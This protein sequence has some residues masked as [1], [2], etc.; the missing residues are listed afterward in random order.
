MKRNI[1]TVFLLLACFLCNAKIILP[2]LVSDGMVLQRDMPVNVWGWADSEQKVELFL[3]SD[4]YQTEADENGNWKIQ[5]HAHSAGGSYNMIIKTND[6][7]ITLNDILFGDVWVCS[8]QSNME[9][10]VHRVLSLYKYIAANPNIRQFLV[11]QTYNFISPQN[12]FISGQWVKATPET[13]MDFTAVGYFFATELYQKH[14]V[15]VGLINNALGGSPVEA[16]ISEDSLKQYPAL[17]QEAVKYKNQSMIDSIIAADKIRDDTWHGELYKEDKGYDTVP[18]YS[19]NLD[20]KDWS[21]INIPGYWD[22]SDHQTVNGAIWF[23]KTFN[24]PSELAGKPALLLSG[25]IVDADDVYVNGK[26]VGNTTYM[27]PPR[28]Y[29]VPENLLKSG[30]NEITIRVVSR[31]G[32]GCFVEDKYY[33]LEFDNNDYSVSDKVIKPIVRINLSGEWL[34]KIGA[35]KEAL[36]PE[37][38]IRWKPVGLYNAK[39]A[40]LLNYTVKGVIWYQGESNVVRASNYQ[41]EF[42]TLI[43]DW[44]SKWKQGDFPFLYVQLSNYMKAYDKPSESDWAVLRE[45]QTNTLSVPNTAMVVTIDIGEWNDIHPLNKKD[46]GKRLALAAEK[47]AYNQDIEYSGP[48][49][50]SM[51]I[52]N[53]KIILSF[54]NADNGLTAKGGELKEFA[55][56]GADGKFVWAKAKIE[57]N[58]VVVWNDTVNIPVSVR[59]AWADNPQYANLYNAEGLPAVPF[60]TANH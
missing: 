23:R 34:Y 39:L 57:G 46:V 51:E 59:Y 3:D 47:I 45:S 14:N 41:K 43:N 53:G 15:P 28:R 19:E 55:I 4:H 13:V 32:R 16:W 5:L 17:Y 30:N 8:G 35:K 36:Q 20:T 25:A 31:I 1:I 40:P 18:W 58:K 50:K 7:T 29:N 54:T 48:V 33:G 22:K 56:A 37:T 42:T 27:Y 49:Y 52:K 6:T 12:D 2:K 24:I 60:R 9:L 10:P 21:K 26:W 11:P 38:F 44:R